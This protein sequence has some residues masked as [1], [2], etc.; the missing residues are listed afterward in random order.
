MNFRHVLQNQQIRVKAFVGKLLRRF[1]MGVF[2]WVPE[3]SLR[4][5]FS[6]L[7]RV[8][9]LGNVVTF[10]YNA[11]L[12]QCNYRWASSEWLS[13]AFVTRPRSLKRG[14]AAAYAAITVWNYEETKAIC[15]RLK[16]LLAKDAGY[17]KGLATV[18]RIE[19][20]S[21]LDQDVAA[22]SIDILCR[23]QRELADFFYQRAW[24][25]HSM[26]S[27]PTLKRSLRIYLSA[28]D[29][30]ADTVEHVVEH[31]YRPNELWSEVL[32][33]VNESISSVDRKLR[34]DRHEHDHKRA[35]VAQR[36]RLNGLRLEAATHI[37]NM[38]EISRSLKQ[39]W[40]VDPTFLFHKALHEGLIGDPSEAINS[41]QSF[42]S[43]KSISN[44]EKAVAY[45]MLGLFYE[46]CRDFDTARLF[47]TEA[48]RHG[49]VP[50]WFPEY[51][52]RYISL[53][54]A[55]GDWDE[56]IYVKREGLILLWKNFE[57]LAKVSIRQR[58][59]KQTVIPAEGAFILGCQG[60]GDDILRLAIFRD[61]KNPEAKYG[62]TCD[63]RLKT[64]F[65]NAMPGMEFVCNSTVFGKF[66][67]SEQSYIQD[68]DG[69][70]PSL[71]PARLTTEVLDR[72]KEYPEI[73]LSEDFLYEFIARKGTFRRRDQ[74][75][76]LVPGEEIQLRVRE[77]LDSL[78]RARG[79][80]GFSWRSGH[81]DAFRNKSYSELREWGAI[82]AL[83][84]VN[85]VN[86]QYQFEQEELD[87][88]EKLFGIKIHT[89]PG[90]DLKDDLEMVSAICVQLEAVVTPGTAVREISAGSGARTYSISS[91]PFYPDLYRMDENGND[92]VF[93]CMQHVTAFHYGDTAGVLAEIANR[94]ERDIES[95]S[96]EDALS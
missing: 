63:P 47:F 78:P 60:V 55:T 49:G 6:P 57:S 85:F 31:L 12:R 16:V 52:W 77:L 36:D 67:K 14:F 40:R 27:G 25:A 48:Y 24:M 45:G 10:G 69:V 3:T 70:H 61:L 53:L 39:G 66:K 72:I 56:A 44:R 32:R 20:L 46:E 8:P 13:Q 64:L 92:A 23:S 74:M 84:G 73:C 5:Y 95:N 33:A 91:T 18:L 4:R 82:F 90:I 54:M 89:L 2:G 83:K 37:G 58:L 19:L 43:L 15:E 71:D 86:L 9:L 30:A 59:K 11:M 50:G 35:L 65:S 87:E 34:T 62:A 75:P 26:R 22:N 81:R 51:L 68:R 21:S 17:K 94:L 93:P 41:L 29:F 96:A 79:N 80:I 76:I 1:G 38:D 42:I 7:T 28:V 88:A